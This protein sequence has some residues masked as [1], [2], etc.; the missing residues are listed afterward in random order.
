MIEHD[1]QEG[2]VFSWLHT[3]QS[4]LDGMGMKKAHHSRAKA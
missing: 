4:T 1:D 3:A 2:S